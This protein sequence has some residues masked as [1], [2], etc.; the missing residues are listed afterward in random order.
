MTTIRWRPPS[1]R[2]VTAPGDWY[3]IWTSFQSDAGPTWGG[4]V[5]LID[6]YS[7]AMALEN[8]PG[9]FYLLS[10]VLAFAY[11]DL[12]EKALANVHGTVFLLDTNHPAPAAQISLTSPDGSATSSDTA[13][14]DGTF[15][16]GPLPPGTYNVSVAG[17]WLPTP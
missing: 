8:A 14:S 3:D 7:T 17:Y 10:D 15:A 2:R 6:S 16:L 1:V 4:F 5:I 11:S 12:L 9:T 13:A